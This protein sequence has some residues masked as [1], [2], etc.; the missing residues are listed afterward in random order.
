MLE[1]EQRIYCALFA[2]ILYP[3]GGDEMRSVKRYFC[4]KRNRALTILYSFNITAS[5]LGSY[6]ENLYFGHVTYIY[7]IENVSRIDITF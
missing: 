5:Y 1:D 7:R 6:L 4:D 2:T 3:N